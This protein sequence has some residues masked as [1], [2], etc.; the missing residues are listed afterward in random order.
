M[1][2]S[3]C[4]HHFASVLLSVLCSCAVRLILHCSSH[5]RRRQLSVS[6]VCAT[7]CLIFFYQFAVVT[8]C[9]SFHQGRL[10]FCFVIHLFFIKSTGRVKDTE[11]LARCSLLVI[12]FLNGWLMLPPAAVLSFRAL[13]LFTKLACISFLSHVKQSLGCSEMQVK[14]QLALY[15]KNVCGLKFGGPLE[16]LFLPSF[17][18]HASLPQLAL[19]WAFY[20]LILCSSV[21]SFPFYSQ[22]GRKIKRDLHHY[23]SLWQ[24]DLARLPYAFFFS[25]LHLRCA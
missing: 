25:P 7:C 2:R 19:H 20:A 15:L 1:G 5:S 13:A 18:M 6:A 8:H 10:H 21:L 11:R 12:K 14:V 9:A 3:R 17:C 4:A 24:L 22:R 16:R 23:P